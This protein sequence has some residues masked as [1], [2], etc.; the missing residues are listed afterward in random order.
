VAA[1]GVLPQQQGNKGRLKC[2]TFVKQN[3]L[4]YLA[5][6]KIKLCDFVLYCFYFKKDGA[7]TGY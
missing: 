2:F 4:F 3:C 5:K 7:R 6:I 1:P